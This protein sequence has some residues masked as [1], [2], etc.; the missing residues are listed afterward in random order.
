MKELGRIKVKNGWLLINVEYLNVAEIIEDN[1]E[2]A[3]LVKK[4]DKIPTID[5][6]LSRRKAHRDKL[7]NR[8]QR[9]ANDYLLLIEV[10]CI[11]KEWILT[12]QPKLV[13]VGA[14]QDEIFEKRMKFYN[15][16]FLK[17]GYH[18]YDENIAV[19]DCVD[20]TWSVYW[21]ME[22]NV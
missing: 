8:C 6:S 21:L 17:M 12:T 2:W 16:F 3:S 1:S 13:Y 11:I 22:K 19:V 5:V 10:I 14:I 18:R 20:D 9:F 4:T 7:K 15:K